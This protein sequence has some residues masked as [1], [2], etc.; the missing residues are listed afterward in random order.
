M[1]PV[2]LPSATFSRGLSITPFRWNITR[3]QAA[4]STCTSILNAKPPNE[5]GEHGLIALDWWNGNCSTLG[6]RT[7]RLAGRND[8]ATRAPDIYRKPPPTAREIIE[9]FEANG[10]KSI[11]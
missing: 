1:K 8:T 5:V 9:T 2:N 3:P 6:Y 11:P 7:Q 4:A 10:C